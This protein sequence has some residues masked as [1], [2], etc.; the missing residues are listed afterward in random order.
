MKCHI[1]SPQ[2]IGGK[3]VIKS[4]VINKPYTHM[5]WIHTSP[6]VR[7][8][9][10]YQLSTMQHGFQNYIKTLPIVCKFGSPREEGDFVCL[11]AGCNRAKK[12]FTHRPS[13][14]AHIR[15]HIPGLKLEKPAIPGSHRITI[16][17]FLVTFASTLT[18][19]ILPFYP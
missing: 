19:H 10:Y 8:Y 12:P 13:I 15:S 1:L 2:W 4:A 17:F 18:L 9:I 16:V 14:T 6:G 5:S 7:E 3:T 11:W